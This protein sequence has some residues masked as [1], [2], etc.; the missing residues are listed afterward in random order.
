[1]LNPSESP[2][3]LSAVSVTL[4]V[5]LSMSSIMD[6]KSSLI[7]DS[8]TGN[9]LTQHITTSHSVPFSSSTTPEQAVSISRSRYFFRGFNRTGQKSK[10][11]VILPSKRIDV[12]NFNVTIQVMPGMYIQCSHRRYRCRTQFKRLKNPGCS[13]YKQIHMAVSVQ[14]LRKWQTGQLKTEL[15]ILSVD[16]SIFYIAQTWT[17]LW[18][19]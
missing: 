10:K 6:F 15:P 2:Y 14:N 13:T 3:H 17:F 11:W 9:T 18:L 4:S 8:L 16:T 12:A 7:K 5:A 19:H 1:M